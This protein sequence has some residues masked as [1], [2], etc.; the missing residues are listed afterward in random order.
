MCNV[1]EVPVHTEEQGWHRSGL[2]VNIAS[3]AR[4][5]EAIRLSAVVALLQGK[6]ELM[7]QVRHLALEHCV[8]CDQRSLRKAKTWKHYLEQEQKA[9]PE[10]ANTVA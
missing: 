3:R 8:R 1:L 6:E 7:C 2:Y 5:A 9:S 4:H 10:H